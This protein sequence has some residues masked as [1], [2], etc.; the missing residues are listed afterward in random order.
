MRAI[1]RAPSVYDAG[2]LG[3]ISIDSPIYNPGDP[4]WDWQTS[5]N[6]PW[7]GTPTSTTNGTTAFNPTTALNI[8][9][10]ITNSFTNIFR[11]IQPLPAGCSQVAGRYGVSTQCSQ[12]GSN[13]LSL[14]NSGDTGGLL[15]SPLVLIG[16]GLLLLMVLK[17]KG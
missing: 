9:S 13:E 17:G 14:L 2:G 1:K 15:S 3:D 5:V 10:G 16:G 11:A 12:Q 7:S 6:Q 4:G 8:M